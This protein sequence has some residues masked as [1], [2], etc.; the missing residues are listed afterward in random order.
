MKKIDKLLVTGFLPPFIVTFFIALFVFVMQTMWLYIDEIAGKGVGFFLMVELVAY[1]SVSMIPMA[2]PVAVLISS[3]MVLG[4]MAERYELAAVKSAGVGL[5]R[6]MRPLMMVTMGI[7]VLSFVCNNWLIPV[8]NL[9]FKSRLYDIRKSKPTLSLAESVFNDDFQG[10]SIRLG[11][12]GSDGQTIED[13]MVYENAET[14]QNRMTAV[15]ADCGEMYGSADGKYFIMHLQ[16]GAQ[17]SEP[18]PVVKDGKRNF[19]M[20]RT[21]FQEWTK[22][23][24]LDEFN[25]D[26]TDEELFKTHH[27]MLSQRQLL[28]AI[29]SIDMEVNERLERNTDQTNRYFYFFEKAAK[30]KRKEETKKE[31]TENEKQYERYQDGR[32]D[33]PEADSLKGKSAS[34]MKL[35]MDSLL[36]KSIPPQASPKPPV[37]QK[38][39]NQAVAQKKPASPPARKG[40]AFNPTRNQK[41]STP[42]LPTGKPPGPGNPASVPPLTPTTGK[43][44]KENKP[45]EQSIAKP[46]ED[47]TSF[48]E[49]F[50]ASERDELFEKAKTTSRSLRDVGQN[51]LSSLARTRES[52][53][54]H[55]FEYHV[56]FSMALACFIF[57]FV[58][59]PLGAIVR[60][61]GF[62]YP[63]LISIIFFMLFI[64]IS[65]FSKNIAERGVIDA[66]L[67][68]WMNCLIVFP[69]GLVLTFW[70]MRDMTM[71]QVGDKF[72]FDKVRHFIRERRR[73]NQ[74]A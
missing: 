46:L 6:V 15:V 48:A 21:T 5:W 2:L 60:K 53:V 20:I 31:K 70:A 68:S 16:E 67:A 18:K 27:T 50:P 51:N 12:K 73:K 11:K 19:P 35:P 39:E 52:R 38:K 24:D 40:G 56:K 65:I 62:G 7:A 25:L 69:M 44:L 49:T 72:K 74:V 8:S 13:V 57:L 58:G 41:P 33:S 42:P 32:P 36:K 34:A 1:L 30:A 55:V 63:L 47:Y 71:Q 3:V 23:F 9:K 54:K 17:Y 10:F 61:G 59:A 14:S 4:N 64:I 22:I 45:L 26:R 37:S 66:V 29:D 28:Y 43:P